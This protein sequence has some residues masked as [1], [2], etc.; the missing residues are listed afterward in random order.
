[1]WRT[2]ALLFL[3]VPSCSPLTRLRIPMPTL[4]TQPRFDHRRLL[5]R[6]SRFD[7]VVLS[8]DEILAQFPSSKKD[9]SDKIKDKASTSSSRYKSKL[10]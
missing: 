9:E 8:A 5:T 1:T 10:I 6:H 7:R 4:T 2:P 3:G